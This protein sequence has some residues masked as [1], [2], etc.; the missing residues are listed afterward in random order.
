MVCILED[1]WRHR[2]CNTRAWKTSV[3]ILARALKLISADHIH[4]LALDA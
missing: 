1:L 2:R 4:V 3:L